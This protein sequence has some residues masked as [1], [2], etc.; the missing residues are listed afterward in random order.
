MLFIRSLIRIFDTIFVNHVKMLYDVVITYATKDQQWAE[1]LCEKLEQKGIRC[2][3]GCRDIPAGSLFSVASQDA[4]AET[5]MLLVAYTK[6]YNSTPQMNREIETAS[7]R[8]FHPLCPRPPPV[9]CHQPCHHLRARSH[10]HL[11]ANIVDGPQG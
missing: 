2:F 1:A 6:N 8:F 10:H 5:R 9:S 3:L 4:L 7:A 11:R